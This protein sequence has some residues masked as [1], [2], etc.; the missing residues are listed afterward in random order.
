MLFDDVSLLE[1]IGEGTFGKVYSGK[2]LKQTMEVGKGRK[3]WQRKT[4]KKKQ[5]I[6]MGLTVA[7]KMLR[8]MIWLC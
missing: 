7:V 5:Q 4:D 8:S 6:K 3:S 1:I 2:L